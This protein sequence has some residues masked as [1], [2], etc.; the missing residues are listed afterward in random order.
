MGDLQEDPGTVAGFVIRAFRS[1]VFHPFQDCK[2]P[3]YDTVGSTTLNIRN[4]SYT[5]GVMFIFLPV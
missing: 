4:E 5:A 3:L 2:T 1:P